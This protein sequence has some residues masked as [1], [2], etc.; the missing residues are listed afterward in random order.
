MNC[1]VEREYF[2]VASD[3]EEKCPH[4][5]FQN[6]CYWRIALDHFCKTKWDTVLPRPAYKNLD[7]EELKQDVDLLKS[8][9]EDEAKLLDHNKESPEYRNA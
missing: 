6:H 2:K 1:S 7:Q 8:Y 9:L 4:P 5:G 3:L